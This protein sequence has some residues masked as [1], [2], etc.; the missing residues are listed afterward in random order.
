[1]PT[2]RTGSKLTRWYRD[3]G[4]I[5]EQDTTQY[6]EL[7]SVTTTH[8]RKTAGTPGFRRL[9]DEG[10]LIANPYYIAQSSSIMSTSSVYQRSVQVASL[11]QDQ[12]HDLWEVWMVPNAQ[13]VT[14]LGYMVGGEFPIPDRPYSKGSLRAEALASANEGTWNISQSAAELGE[15]AVL[16]ATLLKGARQP[17]RTLVD[18][19]TQVGRKRQL[20]MIGQYSVRQLFDD[21]S[22]GWLT[23]R[24]GVRPLISDIKSAVAAYNAKRKL[25]YRHS[26]RPTASYSH[27]YAL[28]LKL[29]TR[30][31][32][33][34]TFSVGDSLLD[35]TERARYVVTTDYEY[36]SMGILLR[37]DLG[38]L[39]VED[40]VKVAWE[41]VPFSF[42]LDWFINV[43]QWLNAID[44][45]VGMTERVQTYSIKTREFS[46]VRC[47]PVSYNEYW[48]NGAERW[49]ITISGFSFQTTRQWFQRD[50]DL[51]TDILRPEW[52]SGVN[53]VRGLDLA[54]F[55]LQL[56]RLLKRR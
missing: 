34:E 1:M 16:I 46:K 7:P 19:A 53:L 9:R 23:W 48:Q 15:T 18:L 12:Y 27:A 51:P 44:D 2:Y 35:Q 13:A 47:A 6:I 49:S 55:F 33:P 26:K 21:A 41:L 56:S 31:D 54:S 30:G 5:V 8:D 14:S 20:D 39:G 37:E 38:L 25:V 28:P 24:Y 42:V 50:V 4:W 43:S 17:L 52:G 36:E 3:R 45:P 10:V 22:A 11:H 29:T 40:A 32:R